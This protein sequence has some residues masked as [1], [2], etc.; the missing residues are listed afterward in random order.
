MTWLSQVQVEMT[1]G[2]TI[3]TSSWADRSLRFDYQKFKLGRYKSKLLQSML[4]WEKI[5]GLSIKSQLG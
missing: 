5:H 1:K 3:T 4:G 2:L